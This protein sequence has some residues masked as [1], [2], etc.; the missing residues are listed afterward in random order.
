MDSENVDVSGAF[1]SPLV[2]QTFASHLKDCA[3]IENNMAFSSFVN[4]VPRG[5][6]VMAVTAVER[7]LTMYKSGVKATKDGSDATAFSD[8]KWGSKTNFYIRSVQKVTKKKYIKICDAARQYCPP[9]G[10]YSRVTMMGWNDDSAYPDDRAMIIVSSDIESD[11][12]ED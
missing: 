3:S 12:E 1:M 5:A 2:L 6:L 11:C 9:V 8:T 10:K 7:A 4:D